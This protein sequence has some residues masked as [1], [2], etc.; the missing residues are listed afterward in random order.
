MIE[1]NQPDRDRPHKR[2]MLEREKLRKEEVRGG[3]GCMMVGLIALILG[4]VG[5]L[6]FGLSGD[7]AGT[8]VSSAAITVGVGCIAFGKLI[9]LLFRKSR[10]IKKN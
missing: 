7:I 8:I 9:V 6:F 1:I 4:V 10:R 3:L 2:L 5:L